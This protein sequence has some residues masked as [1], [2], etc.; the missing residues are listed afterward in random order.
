MRIVKP[1]A[2]LMGP[3]SGMDPLEDVDESTLSTEFQGF[4]RLDGLAML[5]RVEWCARISHRSEEKQTDDSYD[6][7]LRSVVL[8]HGDWSV[9]EHCVISA[10][11]MVDRGLSHELVRHRIAA[12]TQ[13]STRFCNYGKRDVSI[14]VVLPPELEP[15]E[16]LL[17]DKIDHWMCHED[18][19]V[20][21]AED[22]GISE[23][24][25]L[26]KHWLSWHRG[27]EQAEA[28]YLF[29]VN[30][31]KVAPEI[32][33]D[34]LPHCLAVRMI[35]THNLRGWR[36]VLLMRTT[37]QTHRKLRPLMVNLLDE[38]KTKVPVLFEDIQPNAQ[39]SANLRLGR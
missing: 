4:H 8:Q 22:D 23:A 24:E 14:D 2:R 31:L 7:F 33:R 21:A 18:E 25:K 19:A 10:D 20:G 11:L 12:Y 1:Y 38:F 32:A 35:A 39:Q 26:T 30:T 29:Q 16:A 28:E 27:M 13:E 6:R 9:T 36:H 3:P 37:V 5:R 15:L 17:L 34:M